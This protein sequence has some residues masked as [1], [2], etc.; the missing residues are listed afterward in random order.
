MNLA[1][2][3]CERMHSA[4]THWS[5]DSPALKGIYQLQLCTLLD[6]LIVTHVEVPQVGAQILCSLKVKFLNLKVYSE[7][8]QNYRNAF[9]V[10]I[11][12]LSPGFPFHT[13]SG[14]SAVSLP[15][16]SSGSVVSADFILTPSPGPTEHICSHTH[17]FWYLLR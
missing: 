2:L 15:S 8:N 9:S 12:R 11:L 17:A 7:N 16:S 5:N 4:F 6:M 10:F 14:L 13:S 3:Q 1:C